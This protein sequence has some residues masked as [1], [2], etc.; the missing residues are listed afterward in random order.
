MNN[1]TIYPDKEL[2]KQLEKKCEEENRSLNN[3][4][5]TI[6]KKYVES[7]GEKKWKYIN[8]EFIQTKNKLKS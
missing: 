5:T 7:Q 6:L 2:R 3:L 8:L 4:I 1:L